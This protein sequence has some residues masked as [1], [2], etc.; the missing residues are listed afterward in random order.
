MPR[1]GITLATAMANALHVSLEQAMT[2]TLEG[3]NC[4]R[5][6]ARAMIEEDWKMLQQEID[7]L[8]NTTARPEAILVTGRGALA[9]GFAEWLEA[10][11]G[12]PTSL[13]R[14]A[15]LHQLG[16]LPQQVGLGSAVGLLELATRA[17]NG[18]VPGSQPFLNRILARTRLILTE[19]F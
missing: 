6:E 18:F 1:G 19:Y 10:A 12:I 4:R 7:A 9:D 16:D 8:L 14:P 17:S 5:P 11:H 3:S 2:W 15:R 13:G